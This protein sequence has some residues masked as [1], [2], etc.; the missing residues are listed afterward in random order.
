MRSQLI[1]SRSNPVS[2]AFQLLLLVRRSGRRP[3]PRL[4]QRNARLASFHSHATKTF[5]IRDRGFRFIEHD[6][7]ALLA[8]ELHKQNRILEYLKWQAP[9]APAVPPPSQALPAVTITSAAR[10]TTPYPAAQ[11]T[12]ASTAG[13]VTTSSTGG[14]G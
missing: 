12:I 2:K 1:G 8:L 6:N 14:A 13:P 4:S 5:Q 9:P 10:A 7:D 3:A 11:A